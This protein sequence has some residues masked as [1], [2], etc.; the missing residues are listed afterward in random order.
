MYLATLIWHQM[1]ERCRFSAFRLSAFAGTRF[2]PSTPCPIYIIWCSFHW[3]LCVWWENW[4]EGRTSLSLTTNALRF[5]FTSVILVLVRN[6]PL[7]F[8]SGTSTACA[9]RLWNK[10]CA[11]AAHGSPTSNA[12]SH[13]SIWNVYG[14]HWSTTSRWPWIVGG[15]F[16]WQQKSSISH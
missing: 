5:T 9:R 16:F 15:T 4:L 14:S 11:T 7:C 12:T 13:I 2:T 6:R 1:S 3:R 8:S 10:C